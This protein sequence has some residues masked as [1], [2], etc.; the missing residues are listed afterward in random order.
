MTDNN[1]N[2]IVLPD[3]LSIKN[4]ASVKS[5][6]EAV[7]SGSEKFTLESGNLKV[8]D[9]AGIQLLIA[10][11]VHCKKSSVNIEFSKFSESIDRFA[12]NIGID[13]ALLAS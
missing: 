9:T 5:Q 11:L 7:L 8:I 10:F 13:H 2:I 12:E 1:N 6:M 4:V 3:E